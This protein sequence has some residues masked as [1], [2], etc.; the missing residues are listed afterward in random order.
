MEN[1]EDVN[2]SQTFH[3]KTDRII[4][5]GNYVATTDIDIDMASTSVTG[6]EMTVY[7]RIGVVTNYGQKTCRTRILFRSVNVSI[8][9]Q[10]VVG[11]TKIGKNVFDVISIMPTVLRLV[12]IFLNI[13]IKIFIFRRIWRRSTTVGVFE[14][15]TAVIKSGRVIQI[16]VR[17]LDVQ[18]IILRQV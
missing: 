7:W 5:L 10:I 1:T 17:L 18:A 14:N 16:N 9:W 12:R 15:V 11:L 13:R 4:C 6:E 3:T 8:R 2:V